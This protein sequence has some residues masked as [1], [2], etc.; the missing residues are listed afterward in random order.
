MPF[1]LTNGRGPYR[2]VRFRVKG[3]MPGI[4]AKCQASRVSGRRDTL[5]RFLL[6][7]PT[8]LERHLCHELKVAR[9][10]RSDPLP[11]PLE[12]TAFKLSSNP[13]HHA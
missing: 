4:T 6:V 11:G 8:I 7:F 2:N 9:A 3:C 10:K 5:L 13:F 1:Q 12:H